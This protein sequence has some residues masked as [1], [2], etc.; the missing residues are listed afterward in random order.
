MSSFEPQSFL[1][2]MLTPVCPG[3][4]STTS[5]TQ[6]LFI[7]RLDIRDTTF[8]FSL[9]GALPGSNRLILF[10][11]AS[12]VLSKQV[13]L[14]FSLTDCSSFI[15]LCIYYKIRVIP[16]LRYTCRFDSKN[17]HDMIYESSALLW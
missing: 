3:I 12:I 4:S 13:T 8:A 6:P 1:N 2:S 9:S 5:I 16:Q 14:H 15:A 17:T 10:S 7:N 11:T